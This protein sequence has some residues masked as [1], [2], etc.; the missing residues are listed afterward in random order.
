MDATIHNTLD[1][2]SEELATVEKLLEQARDK[3][4]VEI[5]HTDHRRFRDDL[6]RQLAVV[7]RLLERSRECRESQYCGTPSSGLP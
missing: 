4:L 1:L 5:R 3:L 6:R 7:E 2:D